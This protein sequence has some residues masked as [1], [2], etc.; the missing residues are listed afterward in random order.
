MAYIQGEGRGQGTLFPVVLDDLVP[1]DHM[2]RVIEAFVEQLDMDK[3]GFERA[4]PA[5]T[6]RPGYNPR[7]LLKLY[8]YGYLNQIRSSRR[9]GAE[10][11]RNVEVMW[12]LERIY[13]DYKSI[14]EF[15]R[16][17]REAVTAA[18]AELVRF[19]KSIGL[20]RGEWIAEDGSKFRAVASIDTARERFQLQ[21]YLDSMEKMDD[22]QTPELDNSN[23]QAA[24]EKLKNHP[25]PEG[26]FMIMGR[27]T[28]PAYNLQS[29][30][31]AEHAL[32][33]AHDVVLDAAD[34][35]SL[36]PMAN[37]A[38]AVLGKENFYVVAD[39]GYS[40]G[41]QAAKCEAN[42]IM[43]CVPATRTRNPHGDGTFFQRDAFQYQPETDTY[44]CPGQKTLKRKARLKKDKSIIYLAN[45]KDC[46]GYSLKRRC[47]ASSARRVSRHM[48]E[49]A[50]TRMNERATAA[51][52]MHSRISLRH[53]QVP[54]LWSSASSA[55]RSGGRSHRIESCS[56]GLQLE[57]NGKRTRNRPPD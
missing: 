31:D 20:I 34:N 7:S 57:E 10:C 47:T 28:Q 33:I 21:R 50:L 12:L 52:T 22:E 11:R 8:L 45:A 9:I 2:C 53:D 54:Y 41:E 37:A 40:N 26:G 42:G 13:P 51:A 16:M 19:A 55:V 23:V 48:F 44:F 14:S 17:H 24:L 27:H 32:I 4:Q 3:L 18:G 35:R 1:A 25:E 5:D 56:D 6:G 49:D 29:A 38:K 36:E 15:R 39:A 46:G 43:P 30:V